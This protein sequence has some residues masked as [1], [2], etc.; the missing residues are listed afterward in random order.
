[1]RR[2]GDEANTRTRTI[3][4]ISTQPNRVLI[5]TSS[6]KVANSPMSQACFWMIQ[7]VR[8]SVPGS[9]RHVLTTGYT[10]PSSIRRTRP[11]RGCEQPIALLDRGDGVLYLQ[12][13][14]TGGR[15]LPQ[16]HVGGRVIW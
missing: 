8:P 9:M 12:D 5:P 13:L 1:M 3:Q 7:S 14:T 6:T 16:V 4:L 2:E 15:S 10:E 11:T